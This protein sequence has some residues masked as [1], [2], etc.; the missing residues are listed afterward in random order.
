MKL[1]KR[2]RP[3]GERPS[4]GAEIL[5][6]RPEACQMVEGFTELSVH[7]VPFRCGGVSLRFTSVDGPPRRKHL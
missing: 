2:I 7:D 6:M 4:A 1:L 5:V 3:V